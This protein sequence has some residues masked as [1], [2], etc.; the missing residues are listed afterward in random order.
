ML[1]TTSPGFVAR[2]RRHVLAG[3]DETDHADLRL[4]LGHGAQHAE[5]AGGAAHVELHL[6][7]VARRLDRDA[8]R[9]ERD[10]FADQHDGLLLAGAAAVL[11]HDE[12]GRLVAAVRDGQERAH[13]ERLDLGAL[14][15]RGLDVGELLGQRKRPLAEVRGRADVAR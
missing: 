15:H 5:H 9:V 8:A 10:A 13:A 2:P 11:E 3:R 1:V 7:H 14:H 12:P 4:E 6:I